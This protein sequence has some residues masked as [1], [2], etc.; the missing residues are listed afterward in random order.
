MEQKDG[1]M[2]NSLSFLDLEHPSSPAQRHQ[3]SKLSALRT[4]TE[5]HCHLSWFSSPQMAGCE[6]SELP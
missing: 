5:L 3:I 4:L 1:G 6:A 2:E